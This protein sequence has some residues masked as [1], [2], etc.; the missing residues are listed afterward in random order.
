M[1]IDGRVLFDGMGLRP[2]AIAKQAYPS[3]Q[4]T[5][6]IESLPTVL[7]R[8]RLGLSQHDLCHS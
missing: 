3:M 6:H 1:L 5:G 4:P 7:L 2:M 8:N